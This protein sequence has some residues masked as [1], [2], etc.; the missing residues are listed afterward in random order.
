MKEFDY[1]IRGGGCAGLSLA[2]QMD[3][4][5]KLLNKTLAII[6]PR[7]EYKRD[8]TWSFWKTSNHNFEDCIKKEWNKFSIKIPNKFKTIDCNEIPYQTIDSGL[9]YNKILKKLKKNQNVEFFVNEEK[10]NFKNSLVFNSVPNLNKNNGIWQHFG[11]LEIETEVDSFD[12]KTLDLMDF[13][14]DQNRA[15]HF[16]YVLPYSKKT[17]LIETTWLSDMNDRSTLDYEKQIINYIQNKLG[18]KKY[19]INFDEKG[20]IPLFYAN[21]KNLNNIINIGT[22]G[23][24]TRLSTG[25]TFLNIQDHSK[26]IVSN[27]DNP[28]KLTNYII[29]KKYNFLDNIFLKVLNKNPETMP[30]IFYNMFDAP[31]KS[32]IKFLS[33]KS[34]ILE[35]L[36]IILKMP[37]VL[38]L[39]NII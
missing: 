39:K 38:F 8:K 16:F 1:I 26:F 4:S 3:I 36:D 14:C 34:N 18:I 12:E 21:N 11:G 27:L 20:A 6:E 23:K 32:V 28:R 2:Y 15:L 25:Y 30:E 33:N 37:K 10:I 29:P 7:S 35:D 13:D 24:M 19:K 5:G 17:A 22:A 31:N 9:F